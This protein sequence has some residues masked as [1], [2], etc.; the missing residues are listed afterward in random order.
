MLK[1]RRWTTILTVTS[2]NNVTYAAIADVPRKQSINRE[3][4]ITLSFLRGDINDKFIADIETGWTANFKGDKYHLF[5]EREDQHGNKEFDAVLDFFHHFN[6]RWHVDEVDDQSMIIENSIRPLFQDSYYVLSIIDN[7]YA[8]TMNYSKQQNST[9]RFL[10]FIGR[11]NAEFNIPIGTQT[12]QVRNKIGVQRNDVFIHEDDNLV[13]FNITTDTD[14]FCTAIKGYYR[15]RTPAGSEDS[16]EKEPTR[17]YDYISPMASKYGVIWGEPIHDERFDTLA[18]IQA[19]TQEKQESTWKSSFEISAELFDVPLGIGDEVRFI[20]PSKSINGYI[21]VVEINEEFDEDGELIEATYTFGN[22]NI[23]NSYR[24]MQYDALQD[25][26]DLMLGKRKL[27][28]NVLPNAVREA[29]AVINAGENSDFEYRRNGIYGFNI[30]NPLG[31]T[32]YNANGI[33]FSQDG[34]QTFENALTYLGL[35]ASAITTGSMTANRIHGG[36]LTS[37]NSNTTFN[38]NTGHLSM[39]NV[40][41]ELGGG[42]DIHFLDSGNRMYFER[43]DTVDDTTRPAGFGV[44]TN[45]NDRFPYAYMGTTEY[46]A[47]RT[48]ETRGFS[49]FIANTRGRYEID[50]IQNSVNGDNFQIR[51]TVTADNKIIEFQLNAASDVARVI[52]WNTSQHYYHLGY[53]NQRFS[54]AYIDGLYS[55]GGAMFI[56]NQNSDF[57]HQGWRMDVTYGDTSYL[58]FRGINSNDY[59]NL[60]APG[61]RFS[62]IYSV[63]P[64]NVSSDE[65]LKGDVKDNE[66][67]LEFIKK[68]KTKSYRMKNSPT[69]DRPRQY[70]ILAQN[71]LEALEESGVDTSDISMI[72]EGEDGFYGAQYEQFD[73][74]IIRAVQ[75]LSNE[76]EALKNA[77]WT[78]DTE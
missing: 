62:H 22:E 67:G 56:R 59:F 51:D 76:V 27:P 18:G 53:E 35:T 31:V 41:F 74:P 58:T 43:H 30:D 33:G 29:T 77:K 75:E 17:T 14:S 52:P 26:H 10:Y 60:G 71:V 70:G 50:G 1:I 65:R 54:R 9:E 63:N 32:R 6:G 39:R 36:V 38:L 11:H 25:L 45:V 40:N 5:N 24:N 37:I 61:W 8:N 64:L 28:Y 73:A 42:A 46:G 34:G 15:F 49:G 19:A 16:A 72:S 13:D 55:G 68:L 20:V 2:L 21:R 7:F 3:R 57:N 23:A 44:G 78:N 66:L 69:S 4:E 47:L 12:V 48:S